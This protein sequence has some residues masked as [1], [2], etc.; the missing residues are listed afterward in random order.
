MR[1]DAATLASKLQL[2][3]QRRE[4]FY[5]LVALSMKLGLLALVSVSLVKICIAYH[6]RL[7]RHGELAA[8]LSVESERLKGFQKRFDSLFS[9]GGAHRFMD[10]QDQWIAPNRVR[11]IW[12]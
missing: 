3:E 6:Q 10:E 9:I 12:R 2:K 4:L 7:D 1:L 11:I 8:I 5:S